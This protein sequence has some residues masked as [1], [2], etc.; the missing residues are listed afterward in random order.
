MPLDYP[1]SYPSEYST[2][3]KANDISIKWAK[4]SLD[5]FHNSS[6]QFDFNQTLFGICQGGIYEDLRKSGLEQMIELDF[7]GYAV[8][9]LSVGEP[10]KIIYE[11]TDFSTEM[12]PEAVER[13]GAQ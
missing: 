6:P 1:I 11:M 8:G 7:E 4:I 2:S 9:G 12:L 13:N 5:H 3:K 10:K